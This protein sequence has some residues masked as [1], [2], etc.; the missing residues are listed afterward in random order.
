M[1]WEKLK[2][3]PGNSSLNSFCNSDVSDSLVTF[4]GHSSNGFNG[5]NNSTLENGD[6]SLP[7]SG[8]P[9]WETTVM[10]SGWRSNISRIFLV[11]SVPASNDVVGGIEAR[12]QKLP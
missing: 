2:P 6:A 1:Y 7:L 10:T 12:I 5:A 3:M 4:A 11:A 8:R 9:C